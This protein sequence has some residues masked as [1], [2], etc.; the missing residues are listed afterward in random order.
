MSGAWQW[1]VDGA[2]RGPPGPIL[3]DGRTQPAARPRGL[4]YCGA[5][6]R[7]TDGLTGALHSRWRSCAVVYA[8]WRARRVVVPAAWGRAA[9]CCC[10]S[11]PIPRAGKQGLQP[12]PCLAPRKEPPALL[13][14]A[15]LVHVHGWFVV[16][17][18]NNPLHRGQ[19]LIGARV[20]TRTWARASLCVVC[21]CWCGWFS[22]AFFPMAGQVG[23]RCFV[24]ITRG[25]PTQGGP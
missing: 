22:P 18:L 5:E 21:D 7:P 12:L 16:L 19:L 4:E 24:T 23:Q 13:G 3:R 2:L 1:R 6:G 14:C 20:L 17:L 11:A 10:F 25:S 8:V 15:A 9:A